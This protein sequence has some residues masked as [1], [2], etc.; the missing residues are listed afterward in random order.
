[1]ELTIGE[2]YEVNHSRKGR[3]NMLVESQ[4]DEW[5][6]GIITDGQA[7]AILDYNIREQFEEITIRKSLCSFK[8]TTP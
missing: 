8:L 4:D 5:V 6:T 7:G 2:I 3:F 1:M